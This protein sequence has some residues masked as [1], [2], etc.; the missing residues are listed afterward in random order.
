ML[1]VHFHNLTVVLREHGAGDLQKLENGINTHTHVGRKNDGNG[2]C[3]FGNL[4][5]ALSVETGRSDHN[6]HIVFNAERKVCQSRLRTRKV[7]QHVCLSKFL[8]IGRD[9][10]SGGFPERRTGVR[11]DLGHTRSGH[12]CDEFKVVT[13]D[14]C[15]N[16]EFA[17]A[18]GC[19]GNGYFHV[20]LLTDL[21]DVQAEWE[22]N[23]FLCPGSFR[24]LVSPSERD[25][26]QSW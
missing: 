26:H 21:Q 18:T 22:G 16:D 10:D 23:P 9:Q 19:T 3:G 20:R 5:L 1:V 6:A 12:S 25:R 17:H 8:N 24:Q 7:D 11:S 14:N 2:F 13:I 15:F 4:C